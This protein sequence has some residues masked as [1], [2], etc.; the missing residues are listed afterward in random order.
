MDGSFHITTSITLDAVP[1]RSALKLIKAALPNRSV[2]PP[3]LDITCHNERAA[4]RGRV[5]ELE[6]T[7]AL[8]YAP[9]AFHS[10]LPYR[11]LAA[12]LRPCTAKESVTLTRAGEHQVK[13]ELPDIS[14]TIVTDE[15]DYGPLI[16]ERPASGT[17]A[18][19]AAKPL[20]KALELVSGAMSTEETRYYLNGVF[21]QP[22]AE[23]ATALNFVATDGHRLVRHTVTGIKHNLSG[24]IIL[25]KAAVHALCQLLAANPETTLQLDLHGECKL[26]V[27]AT[28]FE[29]ASKLIDGTFVDYNRVIPKGLPLA[30]VMDSIGLHRFL[31]RAAAVGVGATRG[32]KLTLRNRREKVELSWKSHDIGTLTAL[33]DGRCERD[34]EIGFQRQYLG[35]ILAILKTPQIQLFA[36]EASGP[37]IFTGE[38]ELAD[39]HTT[40]VLM[41]MRV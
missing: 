23:D 33:I 15:P 5:P 6:I 22:H 36:S 12:L 7:V 9:I 13:I 16:K 18:R 41:P 10:P 37:V 25:P 4:L 1:V 8:D 19:I 11:E 31:L 32:I 21:I 24:G 2:V 27:T 34:L 26:N 30:A 29:L 3:R 39:P 20:A 35:H 40:I 38:A 28:E 17:T 14:A